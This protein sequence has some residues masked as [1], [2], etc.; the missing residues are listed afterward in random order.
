MTFRVYHIQSGDAN[1]IQYLRPISQK[2]SIWEIKGGHKKDIAHAV[3]TERR[4]DHRGTGVCGSYSHARE[5]SAKYECVSIHRLFERKE[6]AD[7]I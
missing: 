7:D 2:D 4:R 1:I 6:H 5:H 3:R